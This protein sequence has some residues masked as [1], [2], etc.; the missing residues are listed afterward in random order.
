[1]HEGWAMYEGVSKDVF[2]DDRGQRQWISRLSATR[3]RA[4]STE[5]HQRYVEFLS[6]RTIK[7]ELTSSHFTL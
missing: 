7:E 3:Q 4:T 2:R 1:M 5:E 6:N